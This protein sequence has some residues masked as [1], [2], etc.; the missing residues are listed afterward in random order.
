V[1]PEPSPPR[2][3]PGADP[4][5]ASP[6]RPFHGKRSLLGQVLVALALAPIRVYSR[7]VSPAFPRRCK[8]E[9]TCSAYAEQA[10]REL[11]VLR[12]AI[13]AVW[14]LLRCNPLSD[15]GLDPLEERSLFPASRAE[16]EAGDARHSHRHGVAT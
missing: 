16:R 3:Q 6:S 7:F 4:V 12:G 2:A 15:G 11:G 13:V 9:P 5:D 1:S 8:Y 10:I 14:R